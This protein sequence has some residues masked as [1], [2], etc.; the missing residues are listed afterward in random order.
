MQ[1]KQLAAHTSDALLYV[2][3]CQ[4]DGA[5][6][7]AAESGDLE[8]NAR[9]IAYGA[10]YNIS[11]LDY[12]T[13]HWCPAGYSMVGFDTMGKDGRAVAGGSAGWFTWVFC[14]K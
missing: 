8:C 12:G 10:P 2:C 13:T 1:Q 14:C 5:W 6:G 11:K 7:K 4:S 3:S 9:Q